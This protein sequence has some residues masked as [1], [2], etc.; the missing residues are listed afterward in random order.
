EGV[1]IHNGQSGTAYRGTFTDS[2]GFY[3]LPNNAAGSHSISAIKYG[4]TFS[5]VGWANPV[6]VGPHATNR[7]FAATS[8]PVVSIA[9]TDA[10]AGETPGATG[11]FVITRTG[12][13]G[14]PLAVKLNRG[15]TAT[16]NTDY[17]LSLN[18]SGSPLE[19][20]IPAGSASLA[21]T[22]TPVSDT[23]AEGP[24]S[25]MITLQADANYVLGSL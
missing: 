17:T 9:A 24:E 22:V 11:Q 6:A 21:I 7:H 5:P 1:R 12:P 20:T 25:V 16:A 8:M 13:T 19:Y 3:I 4:Y 14:S 10:Q 2:D 18:P 15:G 23:T